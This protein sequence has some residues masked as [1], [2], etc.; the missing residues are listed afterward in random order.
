MASDPGYQA[1]QQ[2]FENA[3]KPQSTD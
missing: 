1:N 2:A 3:A